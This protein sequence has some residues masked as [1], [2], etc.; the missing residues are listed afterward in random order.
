MKIV[1]PYRPFQADNA[2][3][4]RLGL[5]DWNDAL[6]MLSASAAQACDVP[7]VMIT[8]VDTVMTPPPVP[9]YRYITH[10]RRLMP[11]ILE[12][13][14]CYLQSDD[15]DQDTV[16]LSPDVLVYG[17]LRP[18]FTADL[19]VVVRLA[20]KYA[21]RPLLNCAQWWSYA[22]KPQLVAFYQAAL[23]RALT[24]SEPD[25]TWGADTIPLVELLAPLQAGESRRAGLRVRA[26]EL[27]EV[28]AE[29][30]AFDEGRLD[31]GEH[32]PRPILP[33]VDFKYLRKVRM[34]AYFNATVKHGVRV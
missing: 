28:M 32:V 23:A 30:T 20:P 7:V 27:G 29:L 17:D 19:G 12:V 26:I 2:A 5:F 21:K 1:S 11:W 10:Q 6:R 9:S 18:W 16:M 24:L 34:R 4:L 13:A 25:I 31:R 22:A 14:L 33:L 15:F 8:D 3:H